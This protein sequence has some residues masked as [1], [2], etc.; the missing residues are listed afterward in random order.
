VSINQKSKAILPQHS[1][2]SFFVGVQKLKND[3]QTK[4]VTN[5]ALITDN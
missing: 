5:N 2:L 3:W 1:F 4:Q